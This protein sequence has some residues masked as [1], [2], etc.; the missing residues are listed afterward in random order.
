MNKTSDT[1]LRGE[2]RRLA[3]QSLRRHY[4]IFV[5]A[6]LAA[7]ILGTD[8]A[9]TTQVFRIQRRIR[10]ENTQPVQEIRAAMGAGGSADVTVFNDLINGDWQGIIDAVGYRLE[11]L[12]GKETYVG[13]VQLGHSRGVFASIVNEFE[14]GALLLS[15]L[16]LIDTILGSRKLAVILLALLG[17]TIMALFWL[18]VGNVY[19]AVCCRLFLEGRIYEKIPASRFMFLYR[20][21]KHT[22]A[23]LSMALYTL[24]KYL[25]LLTIIG[26]PIKRYSYLLVPY[27]VAENPDLSAGEAV[28]L[29]SRMMKG[30]KWEAFL[31]ELTLLPWTLLSIAT[32]G[33][34]G[35]LFCNPYREAVLAEYSSRVRSQAKEQKVEGTNRLNDRYLFEAPAEAELESAYQDVAQREADGTDVSQA[36]GG[37]WGWL[38]SWFGIVPSVDEREKE[39]RTHMQADL[40]KNEYLD[41]LA[42]KTYPTRLYPIKEVHK[43]KRT[44]N[45]GYMRHY[46]VAA[47]ILLFFLFCMFGWFWEVTLHLIQTG[48]FANRGVLHGPW[49]PI[50]GSGGA[51]ILTLLYRLRRK[52]IAEFTAIII[53]CGIVEY[54]TS[55]ILEAL[56][57]GA[58]WW[59]YTGYYLNLNGRICAE[60]LLVF[61]IG[62][63]A[64]IY[65]LAPVIDNIIE[66]FSMKILVPVCAA[67]LIVF[68]VDAVYSG[69][70]PNQ[71]KGVTESAADSSHLPG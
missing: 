38:E 65:V 30:H 47:V 63:M 64:F 29:S 14:S 69:I 49:L 71:G 36:R 53:V 46:S 54:L 41:A 51:L 61:G 11:V 4:W 52:A 44:D 31:L 66:Q 39:Y 59:D 22:K 3:R 68:G 42:G 1:T 24:L 13:D 62:G 26:Y 16:T 58:K 21:K 34:A 20:V 5:V 40:K 45:L 8:Y 55:W 19:R 43:R 28:R 7:A 12:Q 50:Y 17:F 37:V 60:G 56:H 48:E 70:H 25:W 33:L 23:A 10:T 67:L 57:D 35:I 2:I 18:L 15:A 32:G 6:A 9:N 27:L